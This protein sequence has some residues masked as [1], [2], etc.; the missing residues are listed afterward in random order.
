MMCGL[1]WARAAGTPARGAGR[2]IADPPRQLVTFQQSAPAGRA[3]RLA[4]WPRL[5]LWFRPVH[6]KDGHDPPRGE[7]ARQACA[8]GSARGRYRVGRNL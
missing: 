7:G 8:P 2:Q 3:G 5:A 4:A 6:G 1:V